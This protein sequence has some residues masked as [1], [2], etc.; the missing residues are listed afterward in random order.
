MT[1]IY[2][3]QKNQI[4]GGCISKQTE[5]DEKL[6]LEIYTKPLSPK[7][8]FK[9]KKAT[10]FGNCKQIGAY[11]MNSTHRGVLLYVNIINTKCGKPRNGAQFDREN[12]LYLFK[13][14]G[15]DLIYYEDI[16]ANVSVVHR[17]SISKVQLQK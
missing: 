3:N 1:S 14:M 12:V 8:K 17:L 11:K 5:N 16:T 2:S 9:V 15:F 7:L 10:K 6:A 4:D 13:Q